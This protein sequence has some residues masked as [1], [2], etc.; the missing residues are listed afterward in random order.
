MYIQFVRLLVHERRE[1]SC[2]YHDV[3][4]I[5]KKCIIHASVLQNACQ[6]AIAQ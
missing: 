1:K 6:H 4:Q 5:G 3:E 2:V